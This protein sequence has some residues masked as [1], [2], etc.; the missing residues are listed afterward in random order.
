MTPID[1]FFLH[2]SLARP[3]YLTLSLFLSLP[4]SL[5]L[6]LRLS[7]PLSLSLALSL[8]LPVTLSLCLSIPFNFSVC[9][10]VCLHVPVYMCVWIQTPVLLQTLNHHID[11]S[12]IIRIYIHYVLDTKPAFLPCLHAVCISALSP[13]VTYAF[14][15]KQNSV[16]KHRHGR[17]VFRLLH[18]VLLSAVHV[19]THAKRGGWIHPWVLEEHNVHSSRLKPCAVNTNRFIKHRSPAAAGYATHS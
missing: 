6:S 11:F 3:L 18:C 7:Q 10:C 19:L 17:C 5:S 12:I 13:D 1:V 14:T 15:L 2:L 8:C 16:M 4:L 9:V